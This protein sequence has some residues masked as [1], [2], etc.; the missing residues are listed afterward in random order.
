MSSARTLYRDLHG[1]AP[2]GAARTRL[3]MPSRL[4]GMGVL[5]VL[6]VRRNGHVEQWHF[7]PK[8]RL[9]FTRVTDD[10]SGRSALW[11]V[12]GNYQLDARGFRNISTQR[13]LAR[14]DLHRTGAAHPETKRGYQRTHGGENPREALRGRISIT[15]ELVPVG[16]LY[17]VTYTTDK[18]D[19]TYPYRHPF[20]DEAQ[21]LVCVDATGRQLLLVGGEYT[22]TP[23]G[24]EDG[25]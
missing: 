14:L 3:S 17:A 8:P 13:G 20:E 16:R 12:G 6:E 10:T 4:I 5:D 7:S 15:P 9:A 11:I 24:I 21:P 19:G 25:E 23:H 1:E 2:S 18:N 22:V